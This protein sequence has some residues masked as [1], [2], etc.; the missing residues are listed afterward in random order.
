MAVIKKA[1]FVTGSIFVSDG[2]QTMNM[3]DLNKFKLINKTALITGAG[4]GFY[5]AEAILE[6]GGSVILTDINEKNLIKNYKKLI[7]EFK[8]QKIFYEVLDITDEQKVKEVLKKFTNE[9]LRIDI[10]INNASI[11]PVLIIIEFLKNQGWRI[12]I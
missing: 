10:L 1:A 5:H 12:M 3:S 9:K 8:P 4:A 11:N 6:V 7:K 2:G